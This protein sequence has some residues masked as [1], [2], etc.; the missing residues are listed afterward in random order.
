MFPPQL[1]LPPTKHSSQVNWSFWG[2]RIPD[3][4]AEPEELLLL[5]ITQMGY[6]IL[7]SCPATS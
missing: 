7:I 1:L 6:L 3:I 2:P 5:L 4:R